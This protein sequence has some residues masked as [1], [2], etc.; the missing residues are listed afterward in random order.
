MGRVAVLGAVGLVGL[1]L[2]GL[3]VYAFRGGEVTTSMDGGKTT[4]TAKQNSG[5]G[6][7][8]STSWFQAIHLDRIAMAIDKL[9]PRGV[10]F[11]VCNVA[12]TV[13]SSILGPKVGMTAEAAKESR[14]AL[15]MQKPTRYR[16]GFFVERPR[17]R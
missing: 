17:S 9:K 11:V 6:A 15:K 1:L 4:V 16:V 12:N 3:A 8:L 10:T 7:A 2:I 5:N 13:V 14:P